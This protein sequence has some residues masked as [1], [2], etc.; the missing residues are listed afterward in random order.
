MTTSG[1]LVVS[2]GAAPTSLTTPISLSCTQARRIP[3]RF[4]S[5]P[6]SLAGAYEPFNSGGRHSRCCRT[7]LPYGLAHLKRVQPAAARRRR[8]VLYRVK[9]NRCYSR[10]QLPMLPSPWTLPFCVPYKLHLC[11]VYS[12]QWPCTVPSLGFDRQIF[13]QNM[14]ARCEH[15]SP[16]ISTELDSDR[17]TPR[18]PSCR[19]R[20]AQD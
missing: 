1:M 20:R 11:G 14:L 13:S 6:S 4:S 17:V 18:P 8:P 15:R 12:D 19:R 3:G 10:I 16:G 7:V 9:H 5:A 2:S